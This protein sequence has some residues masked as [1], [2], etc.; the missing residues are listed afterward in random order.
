MHDKWMRILSVPVLALPI[1]F[2]AGVAS[3]QSYDLIQAAREEGQLN[4]IALPHDWCGYGEVIA[5][6]K[7]KYGIEVNEL[8]PDASS[9]EQLEAVRK[10]PETPEAETPDVIDIGFSF[11]PVAQ[12]EGLLAAFKV[13]TWDTIP[14]EL[15]DPE[16]YW[17]ADYYGV[18]AF[19]INTDKVETLPVNWQALLGDEYKGMVA[20]SGD[21]R[22]S[23]QAARSVYAAGLSTDVVGGEEIGAAGLQFFADLNAAGNFVPQAGSRETLLDGTTPIVIGWDYAGVADRDS[24]EEGGPEIKVVVPENGV[25]ARPFVQAISVNAPHPSAAKLWMEF[26]YSDDGQRAWLE[27]GCHPIRFPDLVKDDKIPASVA[28]KLPPAEA[29]E[30]V[31]FPSLEDLGLANRVIADQWDETV[32]AEIN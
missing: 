17:V 11:A 8:R 31:V 20:L 5:R 25:V 30:N 14:D 27:G 12:Q 24:V 22:R 18:I 32:G 7:E 28:E 2:P 26:L 9:A 29:Y 19:S 4:T 15:K 13:G 16:G 3:A 6:F 21:P 1:V 10:S 23:A